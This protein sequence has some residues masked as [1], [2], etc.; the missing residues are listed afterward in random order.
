MALGVLV[1]TSILSWILMKSWEA[2]LIECPRVLTSPV[3]WTIVRCQTLDISALNIHGAIIGGQ[4]KES[5]RDLIESLLTTI[6]LNFFKIALSNILAG[7]V[8]TID[9]YCPNV[10]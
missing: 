2:I 8:L 4:G 1:V 6:G 7:L 5:G 3:V 10:R 9:L